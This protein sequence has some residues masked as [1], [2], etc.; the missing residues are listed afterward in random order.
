[1]TD[2]SQPP[3]QRRRRASRRA[4]PPR[5]APLPGPDAAQRAVT[6]AT[7]ETAKTGGRKP[8]DRNDSARNDS[9]RKDRGGK[10]GGA[11]TGGRKAGTREKGGG[12]EGNTRKDGGER[13]LGDI[14]GAGRS[15][16]GVGGALRARDVNRPTDEDLAEAEASVEIVRRHWT[17]GADAP[18][19]APSRQR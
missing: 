3:R 5:P 16:I 12:R 13:G 1:M 9:A 17:P 10:T 11:R 14:V 19:P 4:G 8:T 15:Q 18:K 7:A 6:S 2:E